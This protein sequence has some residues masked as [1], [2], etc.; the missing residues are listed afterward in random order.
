MDHL[1]DSNSKIDFETDFLISPGDVY[2]NRKVKL[3]DA[4]I[5]EETTKKI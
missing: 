1:D 4:D 3:K 2:P 5:T